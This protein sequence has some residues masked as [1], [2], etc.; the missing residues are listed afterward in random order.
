MIVVRCTNRKTKEHILRNKKKLKG[1]GVLVNEHLSPTN[2][3]ISILVR[4]LRRQNKIQKTW[5]RNSKVYVKVNGVPEVSS[6]LCIRNITE[7]HK[8]SN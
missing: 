5:T 4:T 1:T 2:V 6:V 7:L 8:F 3:D